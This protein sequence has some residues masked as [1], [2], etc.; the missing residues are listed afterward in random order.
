VASRGELP[1]RGRDAD[2]GRAPARHRAHRVRGRRHGGRDQQA[3]VGASAEPRG[4]GARD[5][6][7]RRRDLG[8]VIVTL[9]LV[10]EQRLAAFALALLCGVV[11]AIVWA[12]VRRGAL[13]IVVR[14]L[15]LPCAV[16]LLAAFVELLLHSELLGVAV[17]L[18]ALLVAAVAWFTKR[19]GRVGYAIGVFAAVVAFAA[20]LAVAESWRDPDVQ[21]VAVRLQ[22]N[23]EYAG[24]LLTT[25]DERIFVARVHHCRPNAKLVLEPGRAIAGTGHIDPIL[26]SDI[27]AWRVLP[28]SSLSVA[29]ARADAA[30]NDLRV[31]AGLAK[32]P[33]KKPCA[34]EGT[35]DGRDRRPEPL[36]PELA[37]ELAR[38]FRP[39]LRFDDRERW[40]PLDVDRLL[41]ERRGG[42]PVHRLCPPVPPSDECPGLTGAEQLVGK[43]KDAYIDFEGEA[44]GGAQHRSPSL[45]SCPH[46]QPR[47]LLDCDGGPAS[48]IYY[49]AVAANHR[50]YVDYWWFL[51]YNDF[52]RWAVSDLCHAT[53]IWMVSDEACSVHEGDWEGVT[54]VSS[55]TNPHEL[56]FVDFAK[57]KGVMRFALGDLEHEGER[58]VVDVAAGS[59]AA[60][61]SS[62]SVL[63]FQTG[64]LLP[65]GGHT[66]HREWARNDDAACFT[67]APC[68]LTL[69]T[70]SWNEFKGHWGSTIC[71]WRGVTCRLVTP[72][73][74]PG[75]QDRFRFPWCYVL[76]GDPRLRCDPANAASRPA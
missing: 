69:P 8:C 36:G 47:D 60:Y 76:E 57:H 17:L 70:G 12:A 16:L 65:E 40:R 15:L 34:D 2:R 61:V 75:L 45:A 29:L 38:G 62:C 51:R 13:G 74:A 22:D 39:I 35:V 37:E 26:R 14:T 5:G 3:G 64:S 32:H 67:S 10:T 21:A 68:L 41:A 48:A 28:A 27:S 25:N 55:A 72:P 6:R 66:G 50:I 58:P 63:C 44:L 7:R 18:A 56:E 19:R 46:P 31:A 54:A 30:L 42:Q 20:Y 4:D 9:A 52:S 49:H 53:T 59:H 73:Q 11:A 33:D 24:F 43:G 1:R 23:R 71:K